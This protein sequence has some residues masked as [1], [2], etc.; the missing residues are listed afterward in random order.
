MFAVIFEVQPRK[1]RWNDYL[2]VARSLKPELEKIDGFIDNDR[3]ASQS[4]QGWILSLSTWRDEKAIIRWRTLDPHHVAQARGRSEIFEDYHLR[5]GEIVADT[6]VPEGQRLQ[7]QRFDETEIGAG[8]AITISELGPGDGTG[9][10]GSD[11][12]IDL[13]LPKVGTKGVVAHEAFISIY[14][15]GKQLLLVSWKN[16]AA[17]DRWQPSE[18]AGRSLHHR[19]VR[20]IR[21]YGMGDRREAPQYYPAIESASDRR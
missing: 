8:K 3:F 6:V 14:Q 12:A 17:A 19:A 1:E 9:A 21:D 2:D 13:A 10:I 11:L 18:L 15:P 5:V 16:A 4:S 20:I 7:Q